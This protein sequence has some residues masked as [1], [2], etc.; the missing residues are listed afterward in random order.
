M[1]IIASG[2]KRENWNLLWMHKEAGTSS[3]TGSLFGP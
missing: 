1:P 3:N 2:A